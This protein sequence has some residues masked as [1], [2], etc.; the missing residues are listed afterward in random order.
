MSRKVLITAGGAG[1]GFEIGKA[2][3]ATGDKIY[4]CDIDTQALAAASD[5]LM[6][7][8]AALVDERHRGRFGAAR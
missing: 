7:H 3:A 1:I 8:I 6:R 5:Q 4:T 2:F